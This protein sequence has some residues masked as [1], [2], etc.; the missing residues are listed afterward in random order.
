MAVL[1]DLF[2]TLKKLE[3]VEIKTDWD[4]PSDLVVESLVNNNPNL[5][6]L[7]ISTSSP[8]ILIRDSDELSSR[9]LILLAE[10]CPQLTHIGIGYLTMF[11]SFSI[12]KLVTNCPK[13]KHANFE[14][15]MVDNTALAKMSTNC[16]DLEYL[17]ISNCT[18]ITQGGLERFVY[19]AYAANLKCLDISNDYYSP[20]FTSENDLRMSPFLLKL[21]IDLPNLEIVTVFDDDDGDYYASDDEED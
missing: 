14:E 2:S 16:L 7:D 8:Y 12:T 15:T 21:M 17:K 11:S 19:P 3:V 9:S 20:I 6:H 4:Y 10:K 5:H 13:L 18:S 1:V